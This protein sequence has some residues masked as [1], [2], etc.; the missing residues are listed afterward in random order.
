[1]KINYD[2]LFVSELKK[3]AAEGKTPSL[4]LH[5]CCAPCSTSV[6]ECL[7]EYFDVTVYYF[8]PNITPRDEFVLRAGELKKLLGELPAKNKIKLICADYAPELFGA[9]SAGFEDEKEGGERCL[10][11]FRLRLEGTASLAKEQGF[12]YFTTTLSVSPYKNAAALNEIGGELAEK[13]GVKYLFAD[14]KKK[15]G[16]RRS[17]ELSRKYGL[18]RQ[19]YCGCVFSKRKRESD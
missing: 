15:D 13:Y 1:M 7:T 2:M 9:V 18:Y 3:I 12:D 17:V 5:A 4:L 11:C 8:N 14:F 19:N 10:R 6:L 16:Y